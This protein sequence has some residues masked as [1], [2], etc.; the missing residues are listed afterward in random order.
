MNRFLLSFFILVNFFGVF[1][2][3]SELR[4]DDANNIIETVSLNPANGGT[5]SIT[6]GTP[7]SLNLIT[8]VTGIV[9]GV[10]GSCF[11]TIKKATNGETVLCFST[12]GTNTPGSN[13]PI[14]P[15]SF[16]GDTLVL[17]PP[18]DVLQSSSATYYVEIMSGLISQ[19]V[20]TPHGGIAGSGTWSF[21]TVEASSG[22]SSY[23]STIVAPNTALARTIIT[24]EGYRSY[25]PNNGLIVVHPLAGENKPAP[26]PKN[27]EGENI[28]IRLRMGLLV[29]EKPL[30]FGKG[31]FELRYA[32]KNSGQ[33]CSSNMRY[34]RVGDP[35]SAEPVKFSRVKGLNI[36]DDLV[37]SAVDPKFEGQEVRPQT[38]QQKNDMWNRV[39]DIT[40][41]NVGMWDVSLEVSGVDGDAYCL[42]FYK[43]GQQL[44]KYKIFPEISVGGAKISDA[45]NSSLQGMGRFFGRKVKDLT[46]KNTPE[47][48]LITSW[49]GDVEKIGTTEKFQKAVS[50]HPQGLTLGTPEA[51]FDAI[52]DVVVANFVQLKNLFVEG[53]VRFGEN[54]LIFD[55]ANNKISF[56]N[57]PEPGIVFGKGDNTRF[58]F[59]DAQGSDPTSESVPNNQL[60]YIEDTGTS[61]DL[62]VTG[63]G[64][65]NAPVGIGTDDPVF[66]MLDVVGRTNKDF[67]GVSVRR[68]ND[69]DANRSPFI[70]FRR[71]RG[72]A[73]AI[74]AVKKGDY[75]GKFDFQGVDDPEAN[76]PPY[77]IGAN[78]YAKVDKDPAPGSV[79]TGIGFET[80]TTAPNLQTRLF[81]TS[82]G[83][84]GVNTEAPDKA[85]T[86]KGDINIDGGKLFL[87]GG[88]VDLSGGGGGGPD[89]N[90]SGTLN[91][92]GATT[93]N[94]DVALGSD[95]VDKVTFNGRIASDLIPDQDVLYNIGSVTNRW[96]EGNF[97]SIQPNNIIIGNR[98][99]AFPAN[100]PT[101]DQ[102]LVYTG[103]GF[104]WQ[105]VPGGGGGSFDGDLGGKDLTNAKDGSFSGNVSVGGT[106]LATGKT[107]LDGGVMIKTGA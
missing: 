51:P 37:S 79:P 46:S 8:D 74:K 104:E 48:R 22:A 35:D 58:S 86:V 23:S 52:F 91:V 25:F 78:F 61:A 70:S 101:A 60:L 31:V 19:G 26:V 11:I 27:R 47:M 75:L 89:G 103:S 38:F 41:G 9:P 81:I 2:V 100:A 44:D 68:F 77:Q 12:D 62:H 73:D 32:K 50:A 13:P 97:E 64:L 33:T 18:P 54:S 92:D 84:V 66:S 96:K 80:G 6:N 85:L 14:V 57:I 63:K 1:F 106:L 43:E 30:R 67:G 16:S 40:I 94:G 7:A 59:F 21:T 15:A 20:H 24:Q 82:D 34:K 69:I 88:E 83:K 105:A 99:I 107:T 76:R 10:S 90:F 87:N 55:N 4:A 72:N 102:Y 39:S 36:E 49:K 28:P 17:T 53:V 93:L 3:F 5:L 98:Q 65:F 45:T 71:G 95:Q 56:G 42:A 29:E